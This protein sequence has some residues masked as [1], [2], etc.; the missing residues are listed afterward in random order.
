MRLTQPKR[1]DKKVALAAAFVQQ[2]IKCG[3]ADEV[4][5]TLLAVHGID[6][7]LSCGCKFGDVWG[8]QPCKDHNSK[9]APRIC[10]CGWVQELTARTSLAFRRRD[11]EE[12]DRLRRERGLPTGEN[13]W[14]WS[15]AEGLTRRRFPHPRRCI[16]DYW[17]R[18][19]DACFTCI[20]YW[21]HVGNE[22]T[23]RNCP[24]S[25]NGQEPPSLVCEEERIRVAEAKDSRKW[26][27]KVLV[28]PEDEAE[29]LIE[30]RIHEF[31]IPDVRPASPVATDVGHFYI[32]QVSPD[33]GPNRVKL[34]FSSGL[35]AR[36]AT[37]RTASPTAEIAASWPCR[38]AWENAAIASIT[39]MECEQ[40]G[41]E[42]FDGEDLGSLLERGTE[43]FEIMPRLRS[44]E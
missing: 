43:F 25:P 16:R 28:L 15:G 3:V 31:G 38:P 2:A 34:G 14:G 17:G 35:D 12:V 36:L 27:Q 42:V 8:Y 26:G 32:I 10:L 44:P 19:L 5:Q 6:K 7:V 13:V 18:W 4:L 1:K 21:S 20:E 9:S 41:P 30:T 24:D 11:D 39:R 33:L 23:Q 29:K 37:Y 40:I 22:D